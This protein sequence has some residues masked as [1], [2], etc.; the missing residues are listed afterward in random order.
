MQPQSS[1]S[2]ASQVHGM[3]SRAYGGRTKRKTTSPGWRV[4]GGK[5][6]MGAE[7]RMSAGL[8]LGRRP[9]AKNLWPQ[10]LARNLAAGGLLDGSATVRRHLVSKPIVDMA[11]A[12]LASD[13]SREFALRPADCD[14]VLKSRHYLNLARFL[15][16]VMQAFLRVNNAKCFA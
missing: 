6:V 5:V 13:A 14:G 4:L 3:N 15:A 7:M 16:T 11:R 12:D 10:H 1:L 8:A 2:T 9:G